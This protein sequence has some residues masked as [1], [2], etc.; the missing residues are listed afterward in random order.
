MKKL[1]IYITIIIGVLF[2]CTIDSLFTHP[3]PVIFGICFLV[4]LGVDFRFISKRDLAKI[5]S[6]DKIKK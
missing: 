3:L 2:A 6:D 4:L 1:L 5:L